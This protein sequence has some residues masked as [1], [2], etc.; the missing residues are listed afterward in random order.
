VLVEVATRTAEAIEEL[1]SSFLLDTET[2][3][4]GNELGFD[5]LDFYVCGRGGVLGY[6]DA[7]VVAATLAFFNPAMTLERW[8]RGLGVMPP[9]DAALEFAG[10]LYAWGDQHLDQDHDFDYDRLAG[11]LNRVVAG[12]SPVGAPLFAAWRTLPLP[13]DAAGIVLHQLNALHELRGAMNASCVLAS[14]LDP[15]VA[16]LV[17]MPVMAGIFGWERPY[18]EVG[19]ATKAWVKAERATDRVMA[20]VFSVLD[21]TEQERFASLIEQLK[22]SVR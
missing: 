18:P 7:S 3:E 19:L 5:G 22:A 9:L 20:R 10:C 13:E 12:A 4:R 11:Y 14:G 21:E 6:V 2:Y 17:R 8:R 1:P 15:V 16:V